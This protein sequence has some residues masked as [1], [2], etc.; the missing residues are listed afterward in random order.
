MNEELIFW[1]S[2]KNL[3]YGIL[4]NIKAESHTVLN[5]MGE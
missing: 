2:L 1:T 5:D 3:L 4:L